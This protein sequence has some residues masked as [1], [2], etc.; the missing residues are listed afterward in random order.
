MNFNKNSYLVGMP[1]SK[2]G[3][4][5]NTMR[6]AS[7]YNEIL[8]ILYNYW[9]NDIQDKNDNFIKPL[10]LY[11]SKAPWDFPLNV[12]I[13]KLFLNQPPKII[14]I[15]EIIKIWPPIIKIKN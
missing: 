8:Y 3:I 13:Y 4:K 12:R 9:R 7:N 6:I 10:K 14:K 2:N 15:T 5:Y 1:K 11:K